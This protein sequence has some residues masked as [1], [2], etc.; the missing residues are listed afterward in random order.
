MFSEEK[1]FLPNLKLR[2]DIFFLSFLFERWICSSFFLSQEVSFI[3]S[4]FI[5]SFFSHLLAYLFY[6]PLFLFLPRK[7]MAKVRGTEREKVKE[8]KEWRWWNSVS[9]KIES[10]ARSDQDVCTFFKPWLF[11][12]L[13]LSPYESLP[14]SSI[15]L[16]LVWKKNHLLF[17]DEKRRS[18][19]KRERER[20]GDQVIG[21]QMNFQEEFL[22][23]KSFYSVFSM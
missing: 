2:N 4:Q 7:K 16:S 12:F 22:Y 5:F 21:D 17:D 15:F 1:S 6:L 19:S 18:E 8:E 20:E 14:H 3:L 9:I 13:S 10:R 11:F 23:Q